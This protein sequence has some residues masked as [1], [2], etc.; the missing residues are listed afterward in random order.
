MI[1][2]PDAIRCDSRHPR[3]S[4]LRCFKVIH[5]DETCHSAERPTDFAATTVY[6]WRDTPLVSE[7]ALG[8]YVEA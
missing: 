5:G 3:D 2:A 7:F 4:L 8:P 1:P 6:Q